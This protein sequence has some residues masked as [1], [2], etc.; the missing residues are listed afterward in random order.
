MTTYRLPTFATDPDHKYNIQ[1]DGETFTLEFHRNAR[2]D[3]W[4]M[5]VLDVEQVPVRHGVRLVTGI[6]LLQRV[7]LETKPPGELTVVDTTG[8][9]TE[10]TETSLGQ[11]CQLRYIEEADG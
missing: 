2:A 3:R 9:H 5:T 8:A 10:P 6:D 7:A 1:L 11:E 4:N